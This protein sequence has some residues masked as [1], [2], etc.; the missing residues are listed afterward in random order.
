MRTS[1][2]GKTSLLQLLYATATS[3]GFK[4]IFRSVTYVSMADKYE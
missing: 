3:P 2:S 4:H 1:Q